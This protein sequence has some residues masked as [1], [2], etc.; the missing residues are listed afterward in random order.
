MKSVKLSSETIGN[1]NVYKSIT[2]P[3]FPG[4]PAISLNNQGLEI[5][6]RRLARELEAGL[7][8]P[9]TGGRSRHP[10]SKPQKSRTIAAS[11]VVDVASDTESRSSRRSRNGKY[12]NL[13][14][15]GEKS[16]NFNLN[17]FVFSSLLQTQMDSVCFIWKLA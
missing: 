12:L 8:G 1:T 7:T 14:L 9:R 17:F 10:P 6:R 16:W 5:Q 15:K 3:F 4:S 2:S 13:W 11:E